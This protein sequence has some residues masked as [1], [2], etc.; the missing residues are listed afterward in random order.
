M[1]RWYE[2]WFHISEIEWESM[3]WIRLAQEAD[4]WRILLIMVMNLT[5]SQKVSEFLI[6]FPTRIMLQKVKCYLF[7]FV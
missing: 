3:D 4:S 5:V 1:G 2:N 6:N 7:V